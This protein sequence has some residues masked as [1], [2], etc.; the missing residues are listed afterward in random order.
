[1]FAAAERRAFDVLM[2]WILKRF[3]RK[4]IRKTTHDLQQLESLGVPFRSYTEPYLNTENDLVRHI[5][6]AVMSYFGEHEVKKVC[7][8]VPTRAAAQHA[9]L[10]RSPAPIGLCG[11]SSIG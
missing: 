2:F 1:M 7:G 3:S 6:L 9:S 4:G 11:D 10:P 5:L 8:L